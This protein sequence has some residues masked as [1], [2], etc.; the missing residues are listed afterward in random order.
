MQTKDRKCRGMG[1][2]NTRPRPC[3]S[4]K[5]QYLNQLLSKQSWEP[6]L[7]LACKDFI[8]IFN[9]YYQIAIP[10][11]KVKIKDVIHQT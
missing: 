3:T 1:E 7:N 6:S 4:T 9:Y 8:E 11:V 10:K 2:A 5:L